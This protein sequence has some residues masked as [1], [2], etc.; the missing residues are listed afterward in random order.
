MSPFFSVNRFASTL[1]RS[2]YFRSST[3]AIERSRSLHP[4]DVMFY[5]MICTCSYASVWL[6][7]FVMAQKNNMKRFHWR[8]HRK[9]KLLQKRANRELNAVARSLELSFCM[10]MISHK[11]KFSKNVKTFQQPYIEQLESK[12]SWYQ[13]NTFN[14]S[15]SREQFFRQMVVQNFYLIAIIIIKYTVIEIFHL[16]VSTLKN[17]V[18]NQSWYSMQNYILNQMPPVK[19]SSGKWLHKLWPNCHHYH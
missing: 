17:W 5:N 6:E 9:W 2:Q 4:L 19:K 8:S 16:S 13:Q 10:Y 11:L 18:Y 3:L 12:H 1:L 7:V 14:S 15:A